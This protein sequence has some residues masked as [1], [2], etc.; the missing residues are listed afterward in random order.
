[1]IALEYRASDCR[2]SAPCGTPPL[3]IRPTNEKRR[4]LA[5]VPARGSGK[6]RGVTAEAAPSS[7]I[8]GLNRWQRPVP[9]AV[10]LE[11]ARRCLH[12]CSEGKASCQPF[13]AR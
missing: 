2:L 10:T 13:G 3:L 12:G 4:H 8:Q 7:Q 1:M 5:N 6:R 9:A 11:P